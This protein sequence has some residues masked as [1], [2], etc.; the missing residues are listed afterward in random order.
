MND[1]SAAA[2]PAATDLPF[3]PI[4]DLIREHAQAAPR[5]PALVDS[6]SALDYGALDASMDRVAASLQRDGVAAGDSIA[7]CASNSTRYAAIFLGALRAGVVVA[8]LAASVTR[9]S[10]RSMLADALDHLLETMVRP[11]TISGPS[12]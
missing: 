7:I 5:H 1:P 4:A 9:A 11:P 2:A 6:T 3:R 12:P 10:F 8:P